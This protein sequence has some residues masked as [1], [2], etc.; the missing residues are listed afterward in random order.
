MYT[1]PPGVVRP[2]RWAVVRLDAEQDPITHQPT[3]TTHVLAGWYGGYLSSDEWRLSTRITQQ[4][5]DPAG[6]WTFHTI[7]GSVYYAPGAQYGCTAYMAQI[8]AE[9]QQ[10]TGG[11]TLTVLELADV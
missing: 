4:T 2:D 3:T 11:V 7:S 9:L 5:C 1:N 10:R 8:L 6:L